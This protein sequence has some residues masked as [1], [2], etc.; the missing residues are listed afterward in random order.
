M[1]GDPQRWY[2]DHGPLTDPGPHAAALDDL[3]DTVGALMET[4]QGLLIHD[5]GLHLYGLSPDDFRTAS[6]ET[7]PVSERLATAL[8]RGRPSEAR[9]PL[10]RIFGT[11]RDYALMLTA[12][13]RHKGVPARVRCGF[14]TYF[15]AGFHADHWVCEHW[16]A[17]DRRWARADAQLDMPHRTHLGI[18]LDIADLPEDAFLTAGEAWRRLRSGAAAPASFGHGAAAGAWFVQVNLARDLLALTRREVSTWDGWRDAPAGSR[19]L[20][21]AARTWCDAVAAATGKLDATPDGIDALRAIAAARL[22]PFWEDA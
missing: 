9:A 6:R 13:L 3:P 1:A 22:R 21:D 12:F 14:A 4:V 7:R 17:R 15:R 8:A 10:D 5:A 16:L 18:A 19:P 2:A 20:D 11:C